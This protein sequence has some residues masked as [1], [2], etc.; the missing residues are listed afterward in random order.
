M[1]VVEYWTQIAWEPADLIQS[2][3][4]QEAYVKYTSNTSAILFIETDDQR[5]VPFW[6]P[7]GLCRI[8][9]IKNEKRTIYSDFSQSCEY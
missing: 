1:F 8:V 4:W 3:S 2:D 6:G 7:A 5:S 9:R